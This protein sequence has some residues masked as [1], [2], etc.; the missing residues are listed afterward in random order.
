M[1]EVFAQYSHENIA[2][3]IASWS[4]ADQHFI[5]YPKAAYNLR[6]FILEVEP[7]TLKAPVMMW[8]FK[9]LRG[10]AE[11]IDHVHG[12][13]KRPSQSDNSEADTI[14]GCHHHIKPENILVFGRVPD[15]DLTFKI[16]DFGAGDFHPGL[17]DA[18]RRQQYSKTRGTETYFAPDMEMYENATRSFDMWALGCVFLELHLWLFRFHWKDG[19]GFSTKRVEFSGTELSHSD[20]RFWVKTQVGYVL[21]PAVERVLQELEAKCNKMRAFNRLVKI[22]RQLLEPDRYKRRKASKLIKS[23][24]RIIQQLCSDL[25]A[26]PNFYLEAYKET[27]GGA[28]TNLEM[29]YERI[30][31]LVSTVG[32]SRSPSPSSPSRRGTQENGPKQLC[33]AGTP[34]SSVVIATGMAVD[35]VENG[36]D[37]NPIN[38]ELGS[39]D[40]ETHNPILSSMSQKELESLESLCQP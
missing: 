24:E 37:D 35:S 25:E 6:S 21:K 17:K 11:A 7:F 31:P 10:L 40:E 1:L 16:A 26:N 39:P 36:V 27:V 29:P 18:K 30:N 32:S 34:T 15:K 2:G 38:T 19:A 23:M 4:Q 28:Q 3:H 13:K 9:Q 5:L 20:D 33:V 12:I 14:E 8:F 22:I